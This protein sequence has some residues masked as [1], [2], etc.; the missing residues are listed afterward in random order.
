MDQD[1]TKYVISIFQNCVPQTNKYFKY[2]HRQEE[3]KETSE[4]NEMWWS[5]GDPWTEKRH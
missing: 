5:E 4:L 3:T 1:A 2:C